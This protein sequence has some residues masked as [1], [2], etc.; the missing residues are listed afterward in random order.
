MALGL[1][2]RDRIQMVLAALCVALA[3]AVVFTFLSYTAG[4]GLAVLAV[5]AVC[6]VALALVRPAIGVAGALMAVP[7]ELLNFK[8]GGGAVSPAEAAFAFVGLGWVLRALVRPETVKLPSERDLPVLALLAVLATGLVLSSEPSRVFR[9]LIFWALFYGVYMQIQSLTVRDTKMVVAALVA[10]TGILGAVGGLSFLGAAG[11]GTYADGTLTE[12]AAGTF[13]DPNYFASMLLLGLLPGAA[14]LLSDLRRG[15]WLV[16]PLAGG[17]AGLFSSV[18]RG[19]IAA[20][21]VGLL[22]L[23]LWRRARWVALVVITA[24]AITAALDVNPILASEKV[25]LVEQRLATL[26]DLQSQ[27]DLRPKLWG[28]ALDVGATHPFLGVGWSNFEREANQRG[29]FDSQNARAIENA[30]SIPL[31]FLAELG[32]LGLAALVAWLLQLF[33]R[34]VTAVRAT[35]PDVAAL[36]LGLLAALTA[37]LLQGLTQMQLRVPIVAAAFFVLGGAITRLADEAREP[38]GQTS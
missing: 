7:L 25:T 26:G 34:G 29:V 8:V 20:F 14:L 35:R 31:S 22:F 28:A 30:H 21:A 12:R 37:F 23:L 33:S 38:A 11:V 16:L 6:F 24:F 13:Q 36:A 18:S 17:L 15:L 19:A 2:D 32:V 3:T 5:L 27:S 1:L 4:P 9:V 10:G